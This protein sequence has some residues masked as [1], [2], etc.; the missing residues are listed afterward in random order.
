[1]DNDRKDFANKKTPSIENPAQ[2]PLLQDGVNSVTANI[3]SN[4]IKSTRILDRTNHYKKFRQT[5]SERD[6]QIV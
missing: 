6:N 1:M 4:A 2:E 3:I 5:K